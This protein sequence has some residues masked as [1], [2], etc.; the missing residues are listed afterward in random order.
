MNKRDY[1]YK[2]TDY[3]VIDGDTADVQIDLGFDIKVNKRIRFVNIDTEEI[4]GGTA[5]SKARGFAAKKIVETFFAESDEILLEIYMDATGKY[6]RVLGEF[7]FKLGVDQFT[8]TEV[9]LEFGL[10]KGGK[11]PIKNADYSGYN[12]HEIFQC[13]YS[14]KNQGC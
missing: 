7:Y 13:F 11:P 8:V 6:G 14:L 12:L 9:F 3:R 1:I 10:E 4:R 2:V 5:E